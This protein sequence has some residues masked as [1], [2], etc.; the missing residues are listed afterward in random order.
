MKTC[1]WERYPLP[2]PMAA[3][4]LLYKMNNLYLRLPPADFGGG[5][6]RTSAVN[7]FLRTIHLP[8]LLTASVTQNIINLYLIYPIMHQR[9]IQGHRINPYQT[10]VV[11]TGRFL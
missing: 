3:L 5:Y 1:S 8:R 6:L 2:K 9:G 7:Y 4:Y 11:H 10:P